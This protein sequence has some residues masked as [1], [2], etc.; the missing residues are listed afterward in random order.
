MGWEKFQ[1]DAG[2]FLHLVVQGGNQQ[3]LVL[4]E[5]LPP[6]VVRLQVDEV[7]GVEEARGV[8]A[9][10]RPSHLRDHLGDL[11]KL[12]RRPGAPDS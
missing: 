9:V 1:I 7:F 8:G 3:F 5:L 2:D 6:L 12:G 10:V 4:V 11:G